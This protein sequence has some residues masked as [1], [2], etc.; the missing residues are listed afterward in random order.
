MQK[1]VRRCFRFGSRNFIQNRSE[2]LNKLYINL[3]GEDWVVG[4]QAVFR[5]SM[6]DEKYQI[7]ESVDLLSTGYFL[8]TFK[9]GVTFETN[10][11]YVWIF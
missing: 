4:K 7:I 5:A 11:G 6:K 3:I 2:E 10:K 8:F 1:G 9:S